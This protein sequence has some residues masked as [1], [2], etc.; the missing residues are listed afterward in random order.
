MPVA[1]RVA[2]GVKLEKLITYF[3]FFSSRAGM[4]SSKVTL[5][6]VHDDPEHRADVLGQLEVPADDLTAAVDVFVRRVRRVACDLER[7]H[8]LD[9]R[10]D[11]VG[12]ARLGG[13]LGARQDRARAPAGAHH[14]H[15][16]G[17]GGDGGAPGAVEVV[18]SREGVHLV[19]NCAP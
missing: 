1:S 16:K 7:L 5:S 17:Q 15:G 9:R 2:V 19:A 13:G 4:M 12:D 14:E 3:G 8:R 10:R 18:G 11:L 6:I